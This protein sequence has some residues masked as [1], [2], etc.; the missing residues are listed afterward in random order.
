MEEVPKPSIYNRTLQKAAEY[1]GGQR[2]LA[3]YLKVPLPDLYAWMRPGAGM[4]PL[5]VFLKAVDLVLNDLETP[6]EQ[7]A[8]KVRIVAIHEDRQRAAVMERLEQL[9][10]DTSTQATD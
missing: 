9:L 10:P 4:P 3:R 2:A 1:V 5:A 8:Q 7:R 6:D